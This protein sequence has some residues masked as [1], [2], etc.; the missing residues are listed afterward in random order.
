MAS[1]ATRG[2][3]EIP[4][5]IASLHGLAVAMRDPAARAITNVRPSSKRCRKENIPGHLR[6]E[7]S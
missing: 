7:V 5:G 1:R 2:E 3:R 4:D 6:P